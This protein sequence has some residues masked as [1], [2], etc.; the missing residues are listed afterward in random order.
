[1]QA[2][3]YSIRKGIVMGALSLVMTGGT[4]S[5]LE[6]TT[7]TQAVAL[8]GK[9]RMLP[10]RM[11]KNY[12]MIGMKL[13]H[14]DP[15][16]EMHETVAEYDTIITAL[17]AYIKDPAAKSKLDLQKAAWQQI[18]PML[19]QPPVKAKAL[20]FAKSLEALSHDGDVTV[21]SMTKG[22]DLKA[23]GMAARIRAVSQFLGA[24]YMFKTWGVA[25]PG[26]LLSTGMHMFRASLDAVEHASETSAEGKRLAK[27]IE[28]TYLFFKVM[29][30]DNNTF[31]PSLVHRR[32]DRLLEDAQHLVDT[33]LKK[34]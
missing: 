29:N 31:V 10:M 13:H 7:Q 33:Y 12:A 25:V 27:K 6:I 23:I 1:M 16:K 32:T 11:L 2:A 8:A 4:L 5:A 14:G 30:D 9:T 18:K 20:A 24:A 15:T 21:K 34:Q 17:E 19:A 3:L 28:K 22:S 26:R